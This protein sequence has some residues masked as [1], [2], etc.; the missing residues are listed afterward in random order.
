MSYQ[1]TSQALPKFMLYPKRR[2]SKD[3]NANMYMRISYDVNAV[4]KSLGVR[5]N[6]EN[7]DP[8]THQIV[9]QPLHAAILKQKADEYQQK[10][11]GHFICLPKRGLVI[12]F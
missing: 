3:P 9:S 5:I 2:S 7:W 6:Y 11:H 4:E 12:F 8:C 10:N 1:A